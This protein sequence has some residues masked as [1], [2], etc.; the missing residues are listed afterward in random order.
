M[1]PDKH[2]H[3]DNKPETACEKREIVCMTQKRSN[4]KAQV[5]QKP[6][7]CDRQKNMLQI[8]TNRFR[9]LASCVRVEKRCKL[10]KNNNT[11]K[12]IQQSA[13]S[14]RSKLSRRFRAAFEIAFEIAFKI[15]KSDCLIARKFLL[16]D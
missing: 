12:G 8:E 15:V 13:A 1:F 14:A 3:S 11:G 6:Q 16:E 5:G 10:H 7:N 4:N 9:R 2:E